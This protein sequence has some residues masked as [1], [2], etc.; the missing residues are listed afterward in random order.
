MG[1][2]GRCV[3]IRT[4]GKEYVVWA[5]YGSSLQEGAAFDLADVGIFELGDGVDLPGVV[6]T[7]YRPVRVAHG[8]SA[9]D[10]A[11]LRTP[12][13]SGRTPVMPPGPWGM[14]RLAW[15]PCVVTVVNRTYRRTLGSARPFC[16]PDHGYERGCDRAP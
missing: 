12:P 2:R 15:R 9:P 16:G 11:E 14:A 13:G 5:A 7:T 4:K 8:A 1:S 3:A 10:H 6:A